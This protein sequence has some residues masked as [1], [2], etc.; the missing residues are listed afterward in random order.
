MSTTGSGTG[1]PVSGIPAPAASIACPE[2]L[3]P[4]EVQAEFGEDVADWSADQLQR[5]IDG[6]VNYLEEQLGHSFGRAAVVRSTS[7]GVT[8]E[9]SSTAITLGGDIYEL[10]TYTTLQSLAT[11]INGAGSAYSMEINP[12]T[13]PDTPSALLNELEATACG[14]DYADRVVLCLSARFERKGGAGKTHVFL[15]LPLASVSTVTENGTALT[16]GNYWAIPGSSWLV[17]RLCS[18]TDLGD[19]T[20]AKKPW[21]GRYPGNVYVSYVPQ[22]WGRPPASLKALLLEAMGSRY[23]IGEAGIQSESFGGAYSYTRARGQQASWDQILAGGAIR[24]YAVQL[25]I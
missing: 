13:R 20:H 7:A 6:L 22:W 2:Y 23:A 3:T 4:A 1:T 5:R 12:Q 19:C 9:V 16:S 18:C 10:A 14:P 24:Q 11:A 25:S 15:D 8:V 17:R 21:S